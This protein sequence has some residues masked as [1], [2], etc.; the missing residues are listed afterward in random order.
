MICQTCRGVMISWCDTC[1]M[2]GQHQG[3]LGHRKIFFKAAW[4]TEERV[5]LEDSSL[6]K[7]HLKNEQEF[8]SPHDFLLCP[9]FLVDTRETG[10]K[11]SLGTEERRFSGTFRA[12]YV[13]KEFVLSQHVSF[14]GITRAGTGRSTI[15]VV[16]GNIRSQ[17]WDEEESSLSIVFAALWFSLLPPNFWQLLIFPHRYAPAPCP[18]RDLCGWSQVFLN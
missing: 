6:P 3:P 2:V 5:C 7:W 16:W 12:L 10:L 11:G 4:E 14:L 17:G 13:C 9:Q 8:A 1:L 18:E 15:N